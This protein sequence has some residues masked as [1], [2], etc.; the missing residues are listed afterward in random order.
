MD[1][2]PRFTDSNK[3][4]VSVVSNEEGSPGALT[5]TELPI[6]PGDDSWD[7]EHDLPS[8]PFDLWTRTNIGESLPFPVTPLT[9]TNFPLL[10]NLDANSANQKQSSTQTVRRFYGRLYINEGAVIRAFEEYGLPASLIH[11]TWGSRPRGNQAPSRFRPLRLL[12]KL[13]ALLKN[14][15]GSMKPKGPRHTAAQFF[16]QIDE[17]VD[18]F[19]QRDLRQLDDRALWA[20]GLPIWRERGGYAFAT[21]IRLGMPS[22]YVY[23]LPERLVKWWTG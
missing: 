5:P 2:S 7:R 19:L 17:W 12:S 13:P 3:D 1:F 10:F 11:R 15:L 23:L 6:P 21:N 18:P 8:Q 4:S 9:E 16:A 20:E 14:G 22:A